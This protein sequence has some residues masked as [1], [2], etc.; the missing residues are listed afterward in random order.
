MIDRFFVLLLSS[1]V[2]TSF[3]WSIQQQTSR[4]SSTAISLQ[5]SDDVL[6]RR[7]FFHHTA[8]IV[9]TTSSLTT[10]SYPKTVSAIEYTTE[11]QKALKQWND[12]V[13]TIDNLLD[14]WDIGDGISGDTIRY[15]LGTANFGSDISPL[16]KIDKAFKI[17]RQNDDIDLVE[18]TELTEEFAEV[19]AS[20]DS[21]AYSSNFAGKLLYVWLMFRQCYV[22]CCW[23]AHLCSH[24]CS[25]SR[26]YSII[27]AGVF[28]VWLVCSYL[29][30]I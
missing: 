30:L 13:A 17:L 29:V 23:C 25:F 3:G 28:F 14:N 18:F 9:I 11:Q 26:I 1:L 6:N 27:H 22:Y 19:L 21:Q 15:R 24:I 20:A 16:F 8:T 7:S 4:L 12:S 5:T 10:I 2:A